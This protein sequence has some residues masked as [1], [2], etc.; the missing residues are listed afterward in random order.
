M[1]RSIKRALALCLTA[2]IIISAMCVGAL[3]AGT[4]VKQY[5]TYAVIGDSIPSGYGL[6]TSNAPDYKN[7]KVSH[8]ELVVGSYPQ[9]VAADVGAAN[10][11]VLA[12]CGFRTT[13]VLRMIDK[14]YRYDSASDSMLST[15]SQMYIDDHKFANDVKSV[16]ASDTVTKLQ[17]QY[18]AGV[19]AAD[20]IT[21]NLGSNDTMTYA[22]NRMEAF[23]ATKTSCPLLKVAE[24][25]LKSF[26]TLG[27]ALDTMLTVAGQ[28]NQTTQAL[29]V[30]SASLVQ[31]YN[32][33]KINFPILIRDIQRINP[34]AK[35]LV[36][37]MY[38]PFRNVKL[39][40][41]SLVK[42]GAMADNVVNLMNT[43][44]AVT[45]PLASKY[46]YVDVTGTEAYQ[47]QTILS[48]KFTDNFIRN[49]HPTAAGYVYM[50]KQ[51]IASLPTAAASGT[52]S[53]FVVTKAVDSLLKSLLK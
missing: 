20:L 33:F 43:Y 42:I 5:R 44:M 39:S 24:T 23:L 26:G 50:E 46:D 10:T 30:L 53:G 45:C 15:L 31:G 51:I 3:A 41:A 18:A 16:N 38:N 7:L 47:F 48:G 35:L 27:Q 8:G 34:N 22:L 17:A 13:E 36:V 40:D 32:N 37:G 12:R 9:L 49:V 6:E 14:N 2:A 28:I 29:A 4:G 52:Q 1:K 25:Q 21:V 19:K 11:Y